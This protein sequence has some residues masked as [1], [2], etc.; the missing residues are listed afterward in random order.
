M[1][2]EGLGI[3]YQKDMEGKRITLTNHNQINESKDR[4]LNIKSTM[5]GKKTIKVQ[6]LEYQNFLHCA[7]K[8][9]Y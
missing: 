8:S 1:N 9:M 4:K 7:C 6:Y 2:Q 3:I 5:K